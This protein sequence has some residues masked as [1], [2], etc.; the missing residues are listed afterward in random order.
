MPRTSP[1]V[2]GCLCLFGAAAWSCFD[3][4][5]IVGPGVG[6]NVDSVVGGSVGDDVGSPVGGS[7]CAAN[8]QL[9]HSSNCKH[10]STH[11]KAAIF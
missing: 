8:L 9:S 6:S 3:I 4:D 1:T 5:S 11:C 10:L 2:S 7:V